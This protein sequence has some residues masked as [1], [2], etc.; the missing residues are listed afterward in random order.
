MALIDLHRK[1]K[2]EKINQLEIFLK[3]KKGLS[4]KKIKYYIFWLNK[5]FVYYIFLNLGEILGYRQIISPKLSMWLPNLIMG[6]SG[7]FF[8]VRNAKEKP[9]AF[10]AFVKRAALVIKKRL[11]R[12]I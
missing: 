1:E 8:L 10:P 2:M 6:G 5:F 3:H 11:K 12:K 9:V 7:I 4:E